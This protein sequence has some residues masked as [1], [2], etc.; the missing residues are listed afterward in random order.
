MPAS[1]PQPLHKELS[2]KELPINKE[3]PVVYR[4]PD[5]QLIGATGFTASP[6][7]MGQTTDVLSS[8]PLSDQLYGARGRSNTAPS[9]AGYD[10]EG[11]PTTSSKTKSRSKKSTWGWLLGDKDKQDNKD[12][13]DSKDSRDTEDEDEAAPISSNP[14]KRKV[15][16]KKD[17]A[18]LITSFFKKDKKGEDDG[19]TEKRETEKSML[20]PVA[21]TFPQTQPVVTQTPASAAAPVADHAEAPSVQS[22][23]PL[24]Q[25]MQSQGSQH[26]PQPIRPSQ[27]RH[28]RE[29]GQTQSQAA[30]SAPAVGAASGPEENRQPRSRSPSQRRR[31]QK[32]RNS[33]SPT[34]RRKDKSQAKSKSEHVRAELEHQ[35]KED[36]ERERRDR[37]DVDRRVHGKD[38]EDTAPSNDELV[39]QQQQQDQPMYSPIDP[40]VFDLPSTYMK[41]NM[42]TV[43][44]YETPIFYSGPAVLVPPGSGRAM[45]MYYHR[46]PLHIER[47]IYRLSHLKLANP[48]RPLVQQ[49]LLSN[50]MYAYLDLINQGYQQQQQQYDP[51]GGP[52]AG[53][54]AIEADDYF[55]EGT[56]DQIAEQNA[57]AAVEEEA[58]GSAVSTSSSSSSSSN[59]EYWHEETT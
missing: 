33:K 2:Y 45:V 1:P 42:M 25:H 55:S 11:E 27:R 39:E 7:M 5:E 30:D 34:K 21:Q 28:R 49:V 44:D 14:I 3:A 22:Q 53:T 10:S 20:S 32:A 9:E 15:K 47:A 50:F 36:K 12:G 6:S 19:E 17:A 52:A 31:I 26:Q 4:I 46:F 41:P 24:N 48:R 13:K 16:S 54:E 18:T 58:L 8:I 56:Y 40:A 51:S 57:Y 59:E 43:M 35:G 29:G 38:M 37:M 23:H